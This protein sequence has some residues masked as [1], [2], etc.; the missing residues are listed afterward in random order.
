M[1]VIIFP[2]LLIIDYNL[3]FIKPHFTIDKIFIFCCYIAHGMLYISLFNKSN[4]LRYYSDCILYVAMV[5][6]PFLST[7]KLLAVCIATLLLTGI[8]YISLGKC[9]LTGEPWSLL[10][11]VFFFPLLFAQIGR[12]IQTS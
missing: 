11:K 8:L 12:Y 10:A 2:L 1:D 9:I 4:Q 7:T 6:S 5:S 3:Y